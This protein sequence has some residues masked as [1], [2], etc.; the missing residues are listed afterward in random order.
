[1]LAI[2]VIAV[3]SCFRVVF[4]L[5]TPAVKALVIADIELWIRLIMEDACDPTDAK[6][7]P[8]EEAKAAVAPDA[9]VVD[10]EI[11][12]IADDTIAPAFP[13]VER[14]ATA[15][16]A[17]TESMVNPTPAAIM[18]AL[19]L[20]TLEAKAVNDALAVVSGPLK[21]VS[22]WNCAMICGKSCAAAL[23]PWM[24]LAIMVKPFANALI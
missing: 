6:D 18:D 16:M 24:L 13:R 2:C 14:P 12:A 22:D 3:P 10:D 23:M 19:A 17:I 11:V 8:T 9:I 4:A 1:M 5:L 15:C 20:T 7:V 21:L